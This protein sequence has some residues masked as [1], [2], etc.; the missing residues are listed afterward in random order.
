MI[1]NYQDLR[2]RK[3]DILIKI[4]ILN[5]NLIFSVLWCSEDNFASLILSN[6]I[7]R[8]ALI[9]DS[10]LALI[11]FE[12]WEPFPSNSLMLSWFIPFGDNLQQKPSS[13]LTSIL[14][15]CTRKALQFSSDLIFSLSCLV[16]NGQQN[17][18]LGASKICTSQQT[19]TLTVKDAKTQK[20]LLILKNES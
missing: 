5:L 20:T 17:K 7:W 15:N 12:D 18:K 10:K 6:P 9:W 13:F 4:L 14:S 19:A 1:N 2:G 16:P 3:V 8:Q 11:M